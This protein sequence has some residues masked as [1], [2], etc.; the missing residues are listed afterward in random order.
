MAL[1][2]LT[3]KGG[4]HMDEHKNTRRSQVAAM[5]PPDEVI[6]P[7][8]QH[9]GAPCTPVVAVGD[10]VDRAQI[11]GEVGGGLG[12]P[13]HSS[14]SGTVKAI[15]DSLMPNG[16]RIS[17]VRIQSDGEMRLSPDIKPFA[18]RLS[19]TSSDEIID[20][21]RKAGISG[22][23]GAAFPTYA[24]IQSGIGKA[25]RLIINCA[26][27]E[28][29]I[30]ANHRLLLEN[31]ASV[32]NGAKILLKAFG[33]RKAEIAVEDNK[34][35]AIDKLE[36]LTADTE[37]IEI[38]TLRTKYPQ[39]DE[40][41]LIYALTGRELPAGKLPADLGCVIF[42]AETA[43]AI[44]NAFAKGMPLIE[45]IVTVDGD[46]IK[47]PMNV[48]A[49]IG[50]KISS[51]IDFCGGLIA[52]PKKIINGGPMMGAAQ[53]DPDAPITKGT[54]AILVFSAKA[55]AAYEQP[56]VC[57]HC[58]KCL[59]VCQMHLMPTKLAMFSAAGR[60][61]LCEQYDA[62]SCVECGAC[63]Y[64]CPGYVPITQYIRAAKA[65]INEIKKARA[66]AAA[67]NRPSAPNSAEIKSP[68]SAE[69]N[70]NDNK[71]TGGDAK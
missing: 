35:D 51:L 27:C 64:I 39:G 5:T 43:S 44:F 16:M 9:I 10:K 31:P 20:I 14:I 70:K 25:E 48:L 57:I 60:L 30:T 53:W 63:T 29:Y 28:P 37:L 36:E 11:I 68:A 42:N 38:K 13:V 34:R 67:A 33:L 26:E 41:Q 61:D 58:G 1:T 66:A 23:G 8:S 62:M 6:I 2:P 4:V 55:C 19:D 45:R 50:T 21:I 52:E 12:C 17:C 3:F 7:M 56:P 47:R 22:M 59:T 24:K 54:S 46:C 69:N 32:I 65:K 40:R 71:Q 49:P 18:K 15:A